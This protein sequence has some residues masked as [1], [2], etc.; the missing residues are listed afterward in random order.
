MKQIRD[1][2]MRNIALITIL[3][4]IP[5]SLFNY[6]ANDK[7]STEDSNRESIES[8]IKR[9]DG[10]FSYSYEAIVWSHYLNEETAIL[11]TLSNQ[12]YAIK[13]IRN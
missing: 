13:S 1:V 12:L 5:I 11:R 7:L 2:S 3:F 9:G 6:D 4:F 10:Y 8:L